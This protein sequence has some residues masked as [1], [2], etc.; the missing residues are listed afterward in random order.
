MAGQLAAA[1]RETVKVGDSVQKV[2]VS[3]IR[4]SGAVAW[5]SMEKLQTSVSMQ[6]GEGFPKAMEEVAEVLNSVADSLAEKMEPGKRDAMKSVSRVA[7]QVVGQSIAG[8]SMIDPRRVV[9]A[10][11][12]LVQKSAEVISNWPGEAKQP[13]SDGK[14]RLAV[15][16][17]TARP[18]AEAGASR[19]R[20]TH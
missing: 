3:M 12:E 1:S 15:E 20:R 5:Y 16:V 13:E 10:T 7:E 18:H 9:Q 17:L 14:P 8:L 6:D 11:N 2:M 19:K 4:L